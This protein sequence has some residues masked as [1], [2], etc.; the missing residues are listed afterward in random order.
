V[1]PSIRSGVKTFG[2]ELSGESPFNYVRREERSP[3]KSSFPGTSDSFPKAFKKTEEKSPEK[4][5]LIGGV[6][7]S[8]QKKKKTQITG[9]IRQGNAHISGNPLNQK[10]GTL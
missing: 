2:R 6:W 5:S 1:E 3:G 9:N 10:K 8:A 4:T 7:D